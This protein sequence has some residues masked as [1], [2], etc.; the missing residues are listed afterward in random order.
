MNGAKLFRMMHDDAQSV[1]PG[2][3][4]E[5]LTPAESAGGDAA[6]PPRLR[7]ADRSQVLLRPCALEDLIDAEHPARIVWEVVGRW[8][9]GPFLA[10]LPSRAAKRPGRAATDPQC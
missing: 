8:D 10:P 5:G 9:L 3:C 2:I 4:A 1:F 7:R 6:S